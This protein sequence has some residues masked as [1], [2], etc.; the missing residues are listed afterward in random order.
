[1]RPNSSQLSG[2][3]ASGSRNRQE[4]MFGRDVFVLQAFGFAE[5]FFQNVIRCA[6]QELLAGAGHF[7][8]AFDLLFGFRGQGRWRSSQLLKQRG[9]H[10]L[11]LRNQGPKKV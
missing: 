4:D 10:A 1:M 2:G 9:H 3:I 7:R 11:L 5:C 8:Q 6:A